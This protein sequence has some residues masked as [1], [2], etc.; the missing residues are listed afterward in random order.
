VVPAALG[1]ESWKGDVVFS[2]AVMS[3][4]GAS[5]GPSTAGWN[6]TVKIGEGEGS[7]VVSSEETGWVENGGC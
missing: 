4:Y 2:V 1:D 5:G 6:V 7:G 3:L